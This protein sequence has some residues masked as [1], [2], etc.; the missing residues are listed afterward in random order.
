V[1]SDEPAAL[2]ETAAVDITEAVIAD[3][4]RLGGYTHPLFTG[5]SGQPVP[6]PG[7]GV[8]LLMGGL[9]ERSGHLDHAVALVELR[10]VRFAKMALPGS[11]LRVAIEEQD[12]ATT[13][14]GKLLTVYR[15]T[16]LDGSGE[17]VA[18]AEAVM[19]VHSKDD[20]AGQGVRGDGDQGE[21]VV[22]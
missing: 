1:P 8:L 12:S 10:R 18:E 6:L 2:P 14:S 20:I 13:S 19:L 17:T 16:A 3:L 4:V 7:Q 5:T 22:V 11:T 15:W 9:V 21:G